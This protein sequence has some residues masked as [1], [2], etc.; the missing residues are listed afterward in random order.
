MKDMQTEQ[1]LSWSGTTDTEQSK[2]SASNEEEDDDRLTMVSDSNSK[3]IFHPPKN[4]L[5]QIQ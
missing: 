4:T 1:L 2:T 3:N 5:Y